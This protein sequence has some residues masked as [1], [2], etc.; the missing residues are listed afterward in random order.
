MG[1]WNSG[2]EGIAERCLQISHFQA[3]RPKWEKESRPSQEALTIPA[4]REGKASGQGRFPQADTCL[5]NKQQEE[6]SQS[7]ET[8]WGCDR[9]GRGDGSW[10]WEA[11]LPGKGGALG[12]PPGMLHA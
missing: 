11:D 5:Q 3:I 7:A 1:N 9:L 6:D 4:Q 12:S 10:G 2:L 8:S